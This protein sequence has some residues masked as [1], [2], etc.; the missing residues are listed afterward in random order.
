MSKLKKIALYTAGLAPAAVLAVTSV[1][2]FAADVDNVSASTT[3]GITSSRSV[4]LQLFY[5][6]L[7]Y[8]VVGLAGITITLWGINKFFSKFH[9]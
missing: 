9:K 7:P 8:I 6:N 4:L 5:D 3:A 1:A 2:C